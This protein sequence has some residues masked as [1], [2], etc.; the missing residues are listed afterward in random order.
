MSERLRV[1]GRA[2][3][4]VPG[5]LVQVLIGRDDQPRW[6]SAA[7]RRLVYAAAWLAWALIALLSLIAVLRGY[8]GPHGGHGV[9]GGNSAA[10]AA[11]WLAVVLAVSAAVPIAARYALLGWRI[12][13]LGVL[14]TPLIPGQNHV[15]TGLYCVLAITYAVAGTRYSALRLWWMGALTLIPV[16]L[17][18]PGQPP[19][20]AYPLRVT[21]ILAAP[22][23]RAV[24]GGPL[25]PRPAGAHRAAA[26]GPRA[27]RARAPAGGAQRRAGGTGADRAG[28]A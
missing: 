21:I 10:D 26:A 9:I 13:F 4:T 22:H 18:T 28:D 1:L 11:G 14:V 3:G 7:R 15:D 2:G 17:W 20:W 6:R 16:W 19:D 12:G 24:R 8:N 27:G 23:R 5:A 25:A